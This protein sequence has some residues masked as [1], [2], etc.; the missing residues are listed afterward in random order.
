MNFSF[1]G[2]IRV[3]SFLDMLQSQIQEGFTNIKIDKSESKIF[4]TNTMNFN[5]KNCNRC[6][7]TVVS[8]FNGSVLELISLIQQ[9]LKKTP[10]SYIVA[11]SNNCNV[12]LIF[13]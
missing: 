6:S 10:R 7:V 11:K 13:S 9:N 2:S 12:S 8:D 4:L 3:Q 1:E 5:P